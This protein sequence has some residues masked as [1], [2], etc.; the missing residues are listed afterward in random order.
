MRTE[1]ALDLIPEHP[2]SRHHVRAVHHSEERLN[3][4]EN[5]DRWSERLGGS[6]LDILIRETRV[7]RDRLGQKLEQIPTNDLNN[8]YLKKVKYR[9]QL[10]SENYSSTN[11]KAE[12][13]LVKAFEKQLRMDTVEDSS[14]VRGRSLF[15]KVEDKKWVSFR[16]ASFFMKKGRR[17]MKVSRFHV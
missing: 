7:A 1:T 16:L 15:V 8:D 2:I 10:G 14:V 12:L 5:F 3:E 11:G 4:H 17:E 9:H 6:S 13:R